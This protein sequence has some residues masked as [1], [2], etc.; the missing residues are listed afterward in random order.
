MAQ[1]KGGTATIVLDDLNKYDGKHTI[2]ATVNESVEVWREGFAQVPPVEKAGAICSG[3]EVAFFT[4]LPRVTESLTLLDHSYT[5]MYYAIGKFHLIDKWGSKEAFKAL[6]KDDRKLLKEAFAEA[7]KGLPTMQ[8]EEDP[9][10][11]AY[12]EAEKEWH[13]RY[14]EWEKDYWAKQPRRT[15][16]S[17][18]YDD[19]YDKAYREWMQANPAP[20]RPANYQYAG[21]RETFE[22]RWAGCSRVMEEVT[23]KGVTEFRA[24][25]DKCTF[26]HGDLTDFKALGPFDLVY[27][28]N[29][30]QYAGR[31]NNRTYKPAEW[32]KPGGYIA[33]TCSSYSD[34]FYQDRGET[35]I[36]KGWEEVFDYNPRKES[37]ARPRRFSSS[38]GASWRY[39]IVKT[40]E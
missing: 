36:Q 37:R 31:D 13:T 5:S 16:Q 20:T 21:Y 6:K 27:L 34:P 18:Y 7:N 1:E 23:Q 14:R 33:Y 22:S 11:A 17:F 12:M 10:I 24:K 29:A 19:G 39:R 15:S 35:G 9:E 4:V 28:S 30:L 3:G 40:P 38:M 25:R 26:V 8:D 32:V 2:Y